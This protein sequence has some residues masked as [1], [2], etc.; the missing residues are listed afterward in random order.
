MTGLQNLKYIYESLHDDTLGLLLKRKE[1]ALVCS[2]S[3]LGM[4][5]K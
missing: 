1:A 5:K 4:E 2:R 3:G